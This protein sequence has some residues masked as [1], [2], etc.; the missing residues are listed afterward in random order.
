VS[1]LNFHPKFNI[2]DRLKIGQ[3]IYE[4]VGI[5]SGYGLDIDDMAVYL[6]PEN[7]PMIPKT[8][9]DDHGGLRVKVPAHWRVPMSIL[10]AANPEVIPYVAPKEAE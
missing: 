8:K 6:T 4:V 9:A 10:K 3:V 5:E 7:V 1:I 2:F